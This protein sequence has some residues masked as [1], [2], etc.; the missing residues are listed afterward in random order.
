MII[1]NFTNSSTT[2]A[3]DTGATLLFGAEGFTSQSLQPKFRN[4]ARTGLVQV[5]ALYAD[6]TNSIT[7]QGSTHGDKQR[8]IAVMSAKAGGD[9]AAELNGDN[10][11]INDGYGA[12]T[13]TFDSS[14]TTDTVA[15]ASACTVGVSGGDDGTKTA[16]AMARAI[17]AMGAAG[18]LA[19]F[20]WSHLEDVFI[21][22]N[23]SWAKVSTLTTAIT[24]DA[25]GEDFWDVD[26][27]DDPNN[28]VDL[29][30]FTNLANESTDS[31][32]VTL[33][34]YMR[35]KCADVGASTADNL[36]IEVTLGV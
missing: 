31:A 8:P 24:D 21:R 12:V 35:V 32:V 34:P 13:F 33:F 20:A 3:N 25:G 9:T 5:L 18:H 4:D 1:Q 11:V 15:S 30:T 23:E 22:H 17:N 14:V 26:T 19:V 7:I 6:G 29:V 10:T 36:A 28:W 27:W 16:V 2:N